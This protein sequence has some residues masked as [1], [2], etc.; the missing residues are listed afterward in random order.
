MQYV[1]VVIKNTNT[2][3][4][5]IT[6]NINGRGAKSIYLNNVATSATNY[7][8][9]AGTYLVYY[10][11]GI[12]YFRDDGRLPGAPEKVLF[13]KDNM[14]NSIEAL[15]MGCI[16]EFGHNKL[17]FLGP[18][19][20]TV[21]YSNDGG[22]TWFD[23]GVS[24]A[25]KIAMV[26]TSGKG[27]S[28]GKKTKDITL[29][30]M[31]RVTLQA[32]QS[33]SNRIYTAADKILLNI[34]T[35]GCTNCSA[36]VETM[37]IGNVINNS[38]TWAIRGIYPVEGWSGW[39]S[40][41][42][43]CLFGG[44]ENQTWQVGKVRITLSI[45]ALSTNSSN[46]LSFID[47]R[48]IGHGNWAMPSELAKTGKLYTID[49]SKNATF[50]ANITATEFNGNL[51]GNATS[52]TKATQDGNGDVISDTYLTKV[53]PAGSGSLT[54]GTRKEDS[55]IGSNSVAIGTDVI[56][57]GAGA[58]AIG[59]TARKTAN[60]PIRYATASG[61]YSFA[62]GPGAE[63][64]GEV[65]IAL[66]PVVTASG[67]YSTA[68]GLGTTASGRRSIAL[69]YGTIA[70]GSSSF[71]AGQSSEASGALS[72]T[73][74]NHT[75]ASGYAAAAFGNY[76]TATGRA[77]FVIGQYNV[78]DTE[79]DDGTHG[80]G[81]KKN[82]FIIG[83]GTAEDARSNAM[84]VDWDGNV[85]ATQFNGDLNGSAKTVSNSYGW[86]GYTGD[87]G[88]EY[89]M[90]NLRNNGARFRVFP[91]DASKG[92]WM[93]LN[94]TGTKFG[95]CD[96]NAG[97]YLMYTP[98]STFAPVFNGTAKKAGTFYS[99]TTV[100]AGAFV[101]DT[102]YP[103]YPYRASIAK[104]GTTTNSYA[105]VIF[106]LTEATSGN[107]APVSQTY[108]GGIYIYAKEKPTA[109]ITIPTIIVQ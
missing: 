74:G 107:Y 80:D 53:N 3:Q 51:N 28:V 17:A 16:D 65:A 50:P 78:G 81:A 88:S 93:G 71:A 18:E 61:Y 60:D 90:A 37:T 99:S 6:L 82:A 67:Q 48:M 97:E 59:D 46:I 43:N 2:A 9:K 76:T 73:F 38:D 21:E 47:I 25:D 100:T 56:A 41:P 1:F 10:N 89:G 64:T 105:E 36:K 63:A 102:T 20:I 57:S 77:Q 54:I 26:T 29:N 23:Y 35:N 30:D 33:G 55:T 108:N 69:N 44:Y 109:S 104:S 95:V 45:G 68:L 14:V 79:S 49:T 5:A 4:S 13:S 34:A 101:S 27:V 87:S 86:F 66:G 62:F 72:T 24:D 11:N 32:A 103:N 92:Y 19:F 70:S 31:V 7:N 15:D 83:N 40:I 8:L 58:I 98:T 75:M 96:D 39:N 106:N 84:T 94:S 91:T 12:Y 85:T 22:Q 52:A 42:F